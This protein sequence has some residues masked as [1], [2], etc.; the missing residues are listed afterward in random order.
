MGLPANASP[1][2]RGLRT[3]LTPL[4]GDTRTALNGKVGS[5]LCQNV[6]VLRSRRTNV[7]TA[8]AR[9]LQSDR[10][11]VTRGPSGRWHPPSREHFST[12]SDGIRVLTQP[13]SETGA[14]AM[15]ASSPSRPD[16]DWQKSTQTSRSPLPLDSLKAGLARA[17]T[18]AHAFAD[19][20]GAPCSVACPLCERPIA[21]GNVRL[22]DVDK[23]I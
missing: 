2:S 13:R 12:T 21:G 3:A 22:R 20:H 18:E 4:S 10:P 15:S 8:T 23:A 11:M 9:D 6:D 5:R 1:Q 16:A 7:S 14:A 17:H 19:Y